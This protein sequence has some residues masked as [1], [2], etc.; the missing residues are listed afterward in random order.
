MGIYGG[1]IYIYI[2]VYVFMGIIMR[3]HFPTL[4]SAPVSEPQTCSRSLIMKCFA[5]SP[6]PNA[7]VQANEAPAGRVSCSSRLCKKGMGSGLDAFF[8]RAAA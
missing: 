3:I 2:H 8:G 6:K 5:T 7:Y 4:N 1:V